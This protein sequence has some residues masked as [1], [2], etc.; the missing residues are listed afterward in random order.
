MLSEFSHVK[1]KCWVVKLNL[2]KY[3][4]LLTLVKQL[5]LL[6]EGFQKILY[7][8]GIYIRGQNLC[9]AIIYDIKTLICLT[10][11]KKGPI[12][13]LFGPLTGPVCP[14]THIIGSKLF[15][16][17]KCKKNVKRIRYFLYQPS[18]GHQVWDFT[19]SL[20]R[21]V[22]VLMSGFSPKSW[23]GPKKLFLFA[24]LVL[25]YKIDKKHF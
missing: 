10:V 8:T 24:H 7:W 6:T 21:T 11:V 22:R 17:Q 3:L 4:Y 15:F 20:G 12:S 25:P 23:A 5:T 18:I 9:W 13:T 16:G 2:G 1:A 14:K 19:K